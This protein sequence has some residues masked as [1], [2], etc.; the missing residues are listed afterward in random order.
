MK[1]I[2][3]TFN[4]MSTIFR[5]NLG[6]ASWN[7]SSSDSLCIRLHRVTADLEE[8]MLPMKKKGF[9]NHLRVKK[10]FKKMENYLKDKGYERC[11][12]EMVKSTIKMLLPDV[13]RLMMKLL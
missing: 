12:W 7:E 13:R 3:E 11:A 9:K 6:A 1:T 10:Y 5:K 4:Q 2:L 8:C